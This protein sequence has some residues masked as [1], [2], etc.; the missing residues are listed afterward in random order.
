VNRKRSKNL[1]YRQVTAISA[2]IFGRKGKLLGETEREP[3]PRVG[4]PKVDWKRKEYYTFFDVRDRE[5]GIGR[6]Q[7]QRHKRTGL[8]NLNYQKQGFN[9]TMI[10]DDRA[11]R[12]VLNFCAWYNLNMTKIKSGAIAHVQATRGHMPQFNENVIRELDRQFR[13]AQKR[14]L[15][16]IHKRKKGH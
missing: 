16:S 15:S 13:K 4:K 7:F 11:I 9:S 5:H 3:V 12:N 14:Y 10:L 1:G 8:F 2:N 6:I